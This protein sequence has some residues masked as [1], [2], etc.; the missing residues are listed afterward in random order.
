[1]Y[2]LRGKDNYPSIKKFSPHSSTMKLLELLDQTIE[3]TEEELSKDV[4]K[5]FFKKGKILKL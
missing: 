3:E 2:A 5:D 1:M 4:I